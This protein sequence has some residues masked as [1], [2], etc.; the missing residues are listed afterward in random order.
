M[1][2]TKSAVD[3]SHTSAPRDPVPEAKLR[4][5]CDACLNT[6]VKCSQ[7]KLSCVRCSQHG[8]Q[9]VYSPYRKIGRPSSKA[10]GAAALP[11]EQRRRLRHTAGGI[12][13]KQGQRRQRHQSATQTKAYM[14]QGTQL[15]QPQNVTDDDAAYARVN[16]SPLLDTPAAQSSSIQTASDLEDSDADNSASLAGGPVLSFNRN[17]PDLE[18]M[19]D[20]TNSLD[21]GFEEID[22]SNLAG[23]SEVPAE[24]VP[25]A[26]QVQIF[27][28]DTQYGLNQ[29]QLDDTPAGH[30]SS[31]SCDS[32]DSPA[33]SLLSSPYSSYTPR[34][35]QLFSSPLEYPFFAANGSFVT[36]AL[37][38][39][40][41]AGPALNPLP[42]VF[43]WMATSRARSDFF[44]I[45]NFR[46]TLQCHANLTN[47]LTDISELQAKDL[48]VDLDV[49]LNLDDHVRKARDRIL[50]CPF[51]LA[52]SGCAQTL[53]L[54]TMVMSN[55]LG[56]FEQSCGTPD[57]D[58]A[59]SIDQESKRPNAASDGSHTSRST[60]CPSKPRSQLPSTTRHLT[61]GDMQLDESV[62]LA[63]SRR[64]VRIYLDRQI[65]TLQQLQHQ[66]ERG[67]RDNVS[68]QVTQKLLDDLLRRLEGFIGFVT[69]TD[70]LSINDVC[71]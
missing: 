58:D 71:G 25:K 33:A 14:Q 55:L 6:K 50:R 65:T 8:R 27:S 26:D 2:Q 37:P 34:K 62:K 68:F 70:S 66:L 49:L 3:I 45:N 42:P 21:Y 9:C 61:V 31:S 12:S 63:F 29:L 4:S 7:T 28:P 23:I 69:L 16:A 59:G 56:L 44:S 41:Q 53:M 15:L 5:S 20:F 57:L 43:S 54:I 60:L 24:L 13:Q 38:P 46:C 18:L 30:T 51:C 48:G 39:G 22:W 36:E 1:L 17:L 47:H 35:E 19:T 40:P 32:R 64:L 10:I 52:R 67:D 11:T